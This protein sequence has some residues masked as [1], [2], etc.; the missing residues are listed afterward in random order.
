MEIGVYGAL[1][2]RL[3]SLAWLSYASKRTASA[4]AA[5]K[6]ALRYGLL[7]GCLASLAAW[8]IAV[9]SAPRAIQILTACACVGLASLG[10]GFDISVTVIPTEDEGE[11]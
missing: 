2:V 10:V 6:L 3:A 5:R 9:P 11:K 4:L 1:F 7:V 8:Q